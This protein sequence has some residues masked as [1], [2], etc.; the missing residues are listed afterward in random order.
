MSATI[1]V[2]VKVA[3]VTSDLEA[4][5]EKVR[6]L[7]KLLDAEFEFRG[8]KYGW[9]AI[10]GLVPVVG[11]LVMALVGVYP[12]IIARKHKLGRVVQTRMA[13][14]LLVDWAVGEVPLLGDAFDVAFKANLKNARLLEKAARKQR[15]AGL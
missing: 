5:L 14:N 12:I 9:D 1:P 3:R 6:R 8:V 10:V 15:R 7:A 4:D 2:N 13:M 11:D